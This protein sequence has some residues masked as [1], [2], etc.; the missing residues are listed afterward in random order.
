MEPTVT[1]ESKI[2]ITVCCRKKKIDGRISNLRRK[3]KM[4]RMP[5]IYYHLVH[6]LTL[7]TCNLRALTNL[8]NISLHL[9]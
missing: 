9:A 7:P 2:S 4:S 6:M 5:L 1:V 3:K 8:A